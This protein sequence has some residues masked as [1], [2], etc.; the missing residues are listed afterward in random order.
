MGSAC[1]CGRADDEPLR[2]GDL[3]FVQCDRCGF[4][5][6]SFVGNFQCF[7]FYFIY[8]SVFIQCSNLRSAVPTRLK[9]ETG[10]QGAAA[11]CSGKHRVPSNP[12]QYSAVHSSMECKARTVI[13]Q[14]DIFLEDASFCVQRI[15]WSV[16]SRN[17]LHVFLFYFYM[18]KPSVSVRKG[19]HKT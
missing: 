13:A 4:V 12:V 11:H 8:N 6:F 9:Q 10:D 16:D 5:R 15:I 17:C 2:P 19:Y 1:V 14:A 7:L 3:C 18:P